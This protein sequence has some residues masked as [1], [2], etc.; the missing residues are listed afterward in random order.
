MRQATEAEVLECFWSAE[1]AA[2]SR[3]SSAAVD[4]RKRAWLERDGL[5]FGFPDDVVWE[6]V[7]LTRDE[8]L[9]ILYI[10]WDWWLTVS[11]GTRLATV[12]AEVQGRDE[13]DRAIAMAAAT[14][15]ELIVVGDRE[16]S[17][18]VLLEGHVRLTAYAAFPE[19]LP[20]ELEAYLG[21]SPRIG[22]WSEW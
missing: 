20:D 9:A 3:W 12:A 18:L 13:G 4:E 16:R 2:P 19:Y 7:A 1:L 17:K 6:R 21:V 5:F 15:P 8:V 22:E 10:N 14:N 11:N